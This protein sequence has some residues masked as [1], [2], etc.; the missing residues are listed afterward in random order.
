M[1]HGGPSKSFI[2]TVLGVG[3]GLMIILSFQN[4]GQDY[5]SEKQSFFTGD[6]WESTDCV[7]D[8]VDCGASPDFL[9]ISIDIVDPARFVALACSDGSGAHCSQVIG[10]CNTGNYP[11]TII[12]YEIRDSNGTAVTNQSYSDVCT[13]GRYNIE[14]HLGAVTPNLLYS[15]FVKII[16]VD[17]QNL[18]YQNQQVN[19]TASI[20]FTM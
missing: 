19:G 3:V 9:Q 6:D 17:D 10:R 16:G 11:H 14:V 1:D 20:D 18:R 2:R 8:V 13:E 5:S 15:V 12:Y 4:C 7:S